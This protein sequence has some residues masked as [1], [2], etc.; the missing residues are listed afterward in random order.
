M[1]RLGN[2]RLWIGVE[3]RSV[4]IGHGPLYLLSSELAELTSRIKNKSKEP[5][6]SFKDDLMVRLAIQSTTTSPALP[7]KNTTF[8]HPNS[9]KPL[10]NTNP[11][12]AKKNAQAGSF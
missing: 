10:K 9:Q 12:C 2:G 11:P 7:C 6:P 4:L 5:V 1:R 8:S 3:R